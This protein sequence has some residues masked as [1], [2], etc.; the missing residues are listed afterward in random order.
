VIRLA[1]FIA[2]NHEP[3]LAEWEAFA[4]TCTPAGGSMDVIALRDHA[5]AMLT[6]I[7]ADLDT[8]Q[9]PAAQAEKGKGRAPAAPRAGPSGVARDTAAEEHGAGRAESGFT[10]EQMVSE[11]RAL[12]AS[13]VRLW[14]AAHAD[15]V[16]GA[17]GALDATAL[18]DLTRFHEAIDQS[19]AESVTR[20]T[21][22]MNES[23]EMF[24]AILGH[25]LRTPLGASLMASRFMLET[26]ELPEPHATLTARIASSSTRCSRWSAT[27]WTSRAA[28]SGAGSRSSGPTSTSA[29]WCTTS[30]TSWPPRT[31]RRTLTVDG[32]GAQ[33]AAWDAARISQA[34]ANLLGNALEH[35]MPGE[36]VA[37]ETPRHPDD[38]TIA[39]H[40]R[41]PDDPGGA[42]R[43]HLPPDEGPG[44]AGA[45]GRDRPAREPGARALHRRPHRPRAP[46]AH[47]GRVVGPARDD[48][49]RAPA[50]A[51]MSGPADAQ[52]TGAPAAGPAEAEPPEDR[53][54]VAAWRRGETSPRDRDAAAAPAAGSAT[55]SARG[56]AG[57][58]FAAFAE[59]VRDYAIFLMDPSGRIT[60]WG[61][62]ARR[63]KGWTKHEAEG[64]HLRLLYPAGGAED[65]TAEAHLAWAAVHGE[66]TGE[67][68]RIRSDGGSFWAEVTITTLRDDDGALLGF[69]KL[70]RDLTAR[71]ATEALRVAAS[72]AAEEA[73]AQAVAASEAKSGFL[74]TISHEIRT[75]VNA[76]LGYTELLALELAGPL[77]ADQ[78]QYLE[79]ARASGRQLLAIITQVLDFSRVDGAAGLSDASAVA[80]APAVAEALAGVAPAAASRGVDLAESVC[81]S[82]LVLTAW[83]DAA[84]VRQIL[85]HLLD[86][87]VR[88]SPARDGQAGRVTVRSG[89][90]P[91]GPAA[92]R[93]SGAG[94][95]VHLCVEDTGIG[96]PADRLD[97]IFEPFV[98]ADMRLTRAHGGV[99]LGLAISRRLARR[100]G[101]D[102]TGRSEAGAGSTF[103]LWL[104]A[105]PG[106]APPPHTSPDASP[107]AS[108]RTTPGPE[109][110]GLGRADDR[111][112]DGHA[113]DATPTPLRAVADAIL[114][115]LERI[116]HA[117]VA[118]LRTDPGTPSA[119]AGDEAQLEDHIAGFLGNL[120]GTL[121]SLGEAA[122]DG[123]ALGDAVLGGV[124]G[125][126]APGPASDVQDGAAIQRVVA[127]RHGAQRARLG[128][129]EGEVRREYAIL[130]EELAAAVQRRAARA[131]PGSAAAVAPG[132]AARA[133]AVLTEF[134]ALAERVSVVG[135]RATVAARPARG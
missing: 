74:A 120:A 122:L 97:A 102:V 40:N 18:D 35:G 88:F 5:A 116:V 127:E 73:R 26:E 34:L 115:E 123:A 17:P 56:A 111:G 72:T 70:S 13:V 14:T 110:V 132:E 114:G 105:A 48:V 89:V 15:R 1:T 129:S 84:A 25:D 39:I 90:T 33:H 71:R 7:A 60:F 130:R 85:G 92:A 30:S 75:P 69:A 19:L 126:A 82:P 28:A 101:G 77:T 31:P 83:G 104:P 59:N 79:A 47:R 67:G 119:R 108:L 46:R 96:V 51:R 124:P 76:I 106:E 20:Y 62:G 55:T 8:P 37:V 23:K 21:Q 2:E 95:W 113:T 54:R 65:G 100:M 99:G 86:N 29:R 78:R 133:R 58:A 49:H 27:C 93:L 117:Y 112:D 50:A 36:P 10:V 11:Y 81:D 121:P 91:R 64:A 53:E 131:R 98:Q 63:I 128:W 80:V 57:R 66:Y 12:R 3:I 16:A 24:L 107:R 4:R 68:Q 45:R 9:G 32:R 118:R 125:G 22:D 135:Y 109:G 43:G 94:P 61:D 41:G 38:V 134:L 52:P 42:A 44:G 103:C 6:D 87:A